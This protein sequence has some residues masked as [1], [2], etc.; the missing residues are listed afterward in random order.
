MTLRVTFEIVPHGEE[1]LKH[2]IHTL[3]IHNIGPTASED[4]DQ[5]EYSFE[6]DGEASAATV[7]HFRSEGALE[8][9]RKVLDTEFFD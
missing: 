7:L 5:Y 4:P 6:I 2:R 9:T 3:N 1:N 8:L